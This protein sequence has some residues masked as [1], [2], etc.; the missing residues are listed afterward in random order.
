M[1]NNP[2]YSDYGTPYEIPAF[3]KIQSAHYLPAF[4]EGIKQQE[5]EI[6]AIVSDTVAPNFKNTIEALDLSG[7]L[8][9]RVSNVFYNLTGSLTNDTLQEIAKE[10]APILSQHR[11]NISLNQDLFKKVKTV[12]DQ[13]ENLN[14]TIEQNALLTKVYK[15]F[16]RGGANVTEENKEEFRAINKELSVLTLKFGDNVLAETNAFQLVIDKKEEL[17]GLPQFVV[18]AASEEAKA[19]ELEGKWLFTI[20]KSS[21]IPF[22]QYAENRDYRKKMFKAYVNQGNNGNEY[23]NNEAAK[24][25]AELRLRKA[26]L[27][28]FKTHADYVLDINMAKTPENVYARLDQ[29]WEAALP[30]AKEEALELQKMI[31]VEGGGF[32]LEAWD[33]WYYSEKLRKQKYALDDEILK[34]YFQL[35]NVRQGMFE[36]ATKLWGLQFV[37]H[38]DFPKYHPD[39]KTIEVLEADGTHIGVLLQDFHPRASKRGGAW[40][41]SY[42][43]GYS[44]EDGWQ[45]PIIVMVMNFSKPTADKPSLLTFEEVSTMFHEF[46]H[47]L[48]GILTKCNYQKIS[49]T[50][51]ARDFVELPSQIMENWAGDPQVMKMYARHYETGEVI[52]DELIEK[53]KASSHFN[54]GF[55][56]VEYTSAAFLDMDWHTI[57]ENTT[58]NAEEFETASMNRINMLPEIVVRYRTT[59]FRHI[60]AGGY[61]AGYYG[62]LW[63]EV[64]DADAF[65]AFKET[66]IF[67]KETA[68]KFREFILEKGGTEDPMK[69]Y[70]KFRGQEPSINPMLKRKGLL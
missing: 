47:V 1:N 48:H 32:E 19:N 17:A 40:M 28:G 66:D 52:P 35:E 34:P 12:Y 9:T 44:N 16:V 13:K 63:A 33:W 27:M 24:K 50:S 61:S 58:L 51:V 18:D 56:T 21:L 36:V 64:L 49:G 43:K 11:D 45:T 59:Y 8:L 68:R 5:E 54:Q 22:L 20:Q 14:L 7:S 57:Y 4:K 67:D 60:F 29:V 23:D 46:G 41:S 65:E 26:N 38:N 31:N 53:L 39:V 25:I 69:L 37:E 6:N 15:D 62:Y 70:V 30:K 10:V 42:R 3:D 2:F 55:A